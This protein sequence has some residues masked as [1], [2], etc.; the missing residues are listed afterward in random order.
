MRTHTCMI[1]VTILTCGLCGCTTTQLRVS[2]V[3]QAKTLT[4]T[5]YEQV[6]D[7]LAMFCIDANALPSMVSLKSGSTQIGDTGTLGFLGVAGLSTQFGSS[8][9]IA[10]S[11]SIVDQ[12]GTAPVTDD[13]VLKVLRMAYKNATGHPAWL[14]DDDANDIGH[15]LSQQIGTNADISTN[16]EMLRVLAGVHGERLKTLNAMRDATG[17]HIKERD[18]QNVPTSVYDDFASE[19]I[20]IEQ[21]LRDTLD[22]KF[23]QYKNPQ[24][25]FDGFSIINEGVEASTGLTKETARR[26]NDI[27]SELAKAASRPPGWFHVGCK[28]DVPHNACYVGHFK[29]CGRVCYVWV[30]PEGR[31]ALADF[32]LSV[33]K[34]STTF[35][36]TQILTVPS[37]IQYSP[38]FSR[39]LGR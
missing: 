3:R 19:A 8:P 24:N 25:P 23:L 16:L 6:L 14:S 2:T 9:T 28:K 22:E 36:D 5:Q 1:A 21:R 17:P 4:E 7:N 35:Q 29:S 39:P 18:S 27:Q 20:K 33:L 11:R 10:G 15:D 12:W 13:N 31:E 34:L 26:I 37:G 38:A 32:T 30:C